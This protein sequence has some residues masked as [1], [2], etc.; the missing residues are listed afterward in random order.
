MKQAV[1]AVFDIGKTN[2]KFFLFDEN[3]TEISHE[4]I[5]FDEIP[6]DDGF[7]SE[8]LPKLVEWMKDCVDRLTKDE[9][10]DLK[11]LNFSTYGASLVHLDSDGNQV[12]PFYNYLK[13][14]DQSVL[15]CF[16]KSYGPQDQF[17][18]DTSSPIMGLLNSGFQF[19]YLKKQKPETFKKVAASLHFPQYLSYLFTGK[20]VADYT[21]IGCHT[22]MWDFHNNKYHHWLERE[23]VGHLLPEQVESS[24]ISRVNIN[25]HQVKVGVG[26]HDSSS[27]LV[28]YINTNND[29]FVLVST[30]TWSI[31]MN[32]FNEAEL[33]IEELHQDCLNFIGIKGTSVKASRLFLGKHLSNQ[34][35][36]L[37]DYFQIDYQTYKGIKWQDFSL[38]KKTSKEQLLFD[39]SILGPERF[40]FINNDQQDLGIFDDY[41]DAYFHLM[42][43]LTDLQVASLKLAIGKSEIK[44]IFIDGGFSSSEVFVQLLANKLPDYE[45]YSTSFALGTALGAALLVNYRTLPENFMKENYKIKK[46]SP[47]L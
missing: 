3:L 44:K 2:K 45:I 19:Y 20:K 43:E 36:L 34:A 28:P 31:C 21:S 25:G 4:Y 24:T 9:R 41:Q 29:P 14:I 38:G 27:A 39:H 26:V 16:F 40:G 22:A 18:S 10:Y 5:R 13:P 15:D 7:L 33:T 32:F 8:N 23:E 30:G 47:I 6:D 42:D 12:L 35:K 11:T 37:S 17:A 1:N 46:H